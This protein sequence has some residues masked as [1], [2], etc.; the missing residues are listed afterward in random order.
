MAANM[1]RRQAAELVWKQKMGEA[2]THTSNFPFL[3]P[4]N[5]HPTRNLIRA[6]VDVGAPGVKY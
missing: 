5:T 4:R 2:R 3:K 6:G 1:N